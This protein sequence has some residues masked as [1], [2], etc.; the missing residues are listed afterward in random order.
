MIRHGTRAQGRAASRNA[1]TVAGV[2]G[3][4]CLALAG[5]AR[6]PGGT[7]F[8]GP[9]MGT[10]Y[11]VTVT[12]ADDD[13]VRV[14]RAIDVVLREADEHLSTYS[15]SSEISLL[16]RDESGQ[17]Q[18]VAPPLFAV[19]QEAQRVSE[20]TGGAFDIT[21]APLLELWGFDASRAG[22]D[23]PA[24]LAPPAAGQIA[25]TLRRVGFARLELRKTPRAA[26]RK[27][28]PGMRLT[29]DG[30][31]P[32]YA[33][34]RIATELR[35]LGYA[36]FIVEIGGVVRA[37]GQRPEGGHWRVAV[38][39]PQALS[40]E[41]LLGIRLRDA[42]ASTTGDYRDIRY[43]AAGH[44]YSHTIDPRTGRA[45][46]G[47][48]TSVTVIDASATRADAYATALMAMGTEAG[49]A[50]ARDLRIPALFVERIAKPGEWRLVESPAFKEWRE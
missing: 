12:G 13:R 22:S 7:Q 14:Q 25:Q 3:S 16:N 11:Q 39:V 10:T 4:L 27:T 29:V 42:A 33:V 47:A 2:L 5:C 35:T 50:W 23:A 6:A 9:T 8:T 21:V 45:V 36:A 38:E 41:A 1:V 43:D 28:L 30:I 20:L 17:W 15:D 34:D 37:Q 46:T 32:G 24:P 26:L 31:A 44:G 19:L 49:L 18:D 48:L 40:Q